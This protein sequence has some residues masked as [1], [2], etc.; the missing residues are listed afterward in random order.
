MLQ[1]LRRERNRADYDDTNIQ[2]VDVLTQNVLHQAR[3]VFS[4]LQQL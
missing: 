4:V 3:Q 1:R 2:R